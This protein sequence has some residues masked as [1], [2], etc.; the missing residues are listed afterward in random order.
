M[1]VLFGIGPFGIGI[2]IPPT[3]S[4]LFLS[5]DT[6]ARFNFFGKDLSF[7][8]SDFSGVV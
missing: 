8:G 5:A 1:L 6:S 2:F 4:N 7:F 3:A